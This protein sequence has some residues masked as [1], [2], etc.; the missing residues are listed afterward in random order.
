M[1][2]E[3]QR[4]YEAAA[5]RATDAGIRQLLGDLAAEERTH[6]ERAEELQEA[7]QA[8]G[9]RRRKMRPAAQRLF[10]LQVDTAGLGR[11]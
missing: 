4:F 7:R 11:V 6:A 8:T 9:C 10:L 1:E 5:L 2:V 3:T